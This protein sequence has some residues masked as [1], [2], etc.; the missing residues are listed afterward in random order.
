MRDDGC[1]H[2]GAVRGLGWTGLLD[3]DVRAQEDST[4]IRMGFFLMNTQ[5]LLILAHEQSSLP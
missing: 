3:A 2:V 5:I 4:Y 1:G